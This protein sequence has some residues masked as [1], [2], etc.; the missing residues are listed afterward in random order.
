MNSYVFIAIALVI[1][2]GT[3]FPVFSELIEGVRITVG[4]P[5]FDDVV[6]PLLIAMLALIAVTTALPWRRATPASIARRV[7]VPAALTLVATIA[8]AVLGLGDP[9]ALATVAAAISI[10][11]M[12]GREYWAGARGR[13]RASGRNWAVAFASLF[14][15]DQQRYGG[16]LVHV[17]VAVM[18]IAIVASTVYQ[19][20][21]RAVL[22]PGESFEVGRY[23][24]TFEGLEERNPNV[25]GDRRG[26]RRPRDGAPRRRGG[27]DAGARTALLPQL[28]GAA[29]GDGVGS[30]A[31]GVRTC[32]RSCR[33]S[34]MAR[35]SCRASS[36]PWCA[37]CGWAARSSPSAPS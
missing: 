13:R 17:G 6:G 34:R 7:R 37:G 4:P 12:T 5:F 11:A 1:L 22:A 10:L 18:A 27:R 32:T 26:A 30:W 3:L 19:E 25:N 15:R 29:D 31:A 28:P 21:V 16:Y 36:I 9:F 35:S 14:P 24:L 2:G 33:A 23:E 8:L 20:Q